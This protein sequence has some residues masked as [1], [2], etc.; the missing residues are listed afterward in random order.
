[1]QLILNHVPK[2]LY[3]NQHFQ[4]IF[5]KGFAFLP[6]MAM[7]FGSFI[8]TDDFTRV[9]GQSDITDGIGI[10]FHNIF[11]DNVDTQTNKR[12]S[13]RPMEP[14]YVRRS[15]AWVSTTTIKIYV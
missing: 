15:L 4:V 9:T 11:Q 12:K 8:V 5:F 13:N 14:P 6:D 3:L 1:M 10:V 2:W 7:H